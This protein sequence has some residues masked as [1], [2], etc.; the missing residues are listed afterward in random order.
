MPRINPNVIERLIAALGDYGFDPTT[1][2][3]RSELAIHA[4]V[5]VASLQMLFVAGEDQPR[6]I[7]LLCKLIEFPIEHLTTEADSKLT[8]ASV[9]PYLGGEPIRVLIPA[10]AQFPELSP[11]L[12]FFPH[13]AGLMIGTRAAG[14]PAV[15]SLYTVEG[16]DIIDVMRCAAVLDDGTAIL[17]SELDDGVRL[18]IRSPS[19]GELRLVTAADGTTAPEPV[20]TG[21]IVWIIAPA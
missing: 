2:D 19:P 15:G 7:D 8:L 14:T 18:A 21:R 6:T 1:P 13:E 10:S 12:F 16:E 3:G 4:G 20:I 5:P 11:A 9:F 17:A